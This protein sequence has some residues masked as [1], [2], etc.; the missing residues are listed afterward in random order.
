MKPNEDLE[1]DQIVLAKAILQLASDAATQ[2]DYDGEQMVGS[3]VLLDNE[4][5]LRRII[6]TPPTEPGKEE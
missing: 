4:A 6:S 3:G 5:D 1:R 2:W